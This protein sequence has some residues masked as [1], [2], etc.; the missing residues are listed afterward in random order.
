M[1]TRA[2]LD[3]P[4]PEP[5]PDPSTTLAVMV[6]HHTHWDREWWTT[7][8]DFAVRLAD[9]LDQ[10]LDILDAD[11]SFTT[12]VLDGQMV[13][14]EDYLELRP[15]QRARLVARIR[16]GRIHVGPW[17]V[18]A[19][20]LLPSG[21][22]AV[23]NLWLGRRVAREL[24]VPTMA[25]GYLP[26][27]FGHAAQLPQIL[28]GFGID[29]AVVW[30]GFGAPPPGQ[31]ADPNALDLAAP[32]ADG[33]PYYPRIFS[34]GRFPEEMQSEF[35]WE[36]PDGSRVLGIYLAHE[37]YVSHA[38][39][40]AL[41]DEAS[42]RG[43]VERERRTIDFLR[44]F[45][46]S[47]RVLHPY[48]GDH[49]PA[50]GRLPE[51]LRRLNAELEADGI[52]LTQ[53]SLVSYLDDARSDA[54]RIAITW[55]GEGRA[56]GR[57]AHLLPGVAS[58]RLYL[59]RL[60]R[61]AE[62]TLERHAEP[63]QALGWM[64]GD[65]YEGSALWAAWR[66]VVQNQPHDSIT[67]CSIDEV[68]RQNV[69]RYEEA[70]DLGRFLALRAGERLAAR[71]AIDD[72]SEG[73]RPFVVFN[74]LGFTRTD[75]A[76]TLVDPT[77]EVRPGAWR[78][79]ND[80]GAEVPF[81]A[82]QVTERRT[83]LPS[84]SWT[85]VAFVADAVPS[86]GY[87]RYHL[88]PREGAAARPWALDHTVL[89]IVARDKGAARTSGLA[90]GPGR[91]EN[92]ELRVLVSDRD[93]S[94][95]V[96]DV[97]SGEVYAGLN[98]L[99][100][101]GD[102]GD[103]YNHSWPIGDVRLSTRDVRPRLTWIETGPARATL[104]VSWALPVPESLSEDR[105]SRS[106]AWTRLE[107]HSDVTLHA[108]VPRVDIRTHGTNTARD[109]RLRALFPL[110]RAVELSKAESAFCVVGRPVAVDEVERGS[111]EPAVPEF[112]QQTFASVDAGGRGLT[113]ANRGLSEASVA[114]DGSGT[115][116]LTLIRAVGYLS[117]GDLLSRIEG[118]GPVMPTPEA[119]MEGPFEAEYSI[120][121]HAGSWSA[122][123]AHR[124]A[125][126]FNARLLSIDLPGSRPATDPW[127]RRPTGVAAD[128]P[129]RASFLEVEG[130][131]EISA[132]KR[133]EDRD[134]L[135]VRLLNESADPRPARIRPIRRGAVARRLN[136]A[137]E[138][139]ERLDIGADG[140]ISIEL[141]A[142]ELATIGI[143]LGP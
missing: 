12:F 6:Y 95:T 96:T 55:R 35:W 64:L 33:L 17:Y 69:A 13:M 121:P 124:E 106:S 48:G 86:L 72:L 97:R 88:V 18:L 5:P 76:R 41:E 11:P 129:G 4:T 94:L 142:W 87:R 79:V 136:L 28:R 81:Q 90:I 104:R 131:V 59:K 103:E 49:L 122:A 37:Y 139:A 14:L 140:W 135:V 30:R 39:D 70:I 2:T 100:D 125:H 46:S 56:F 137:E 111:A 116:A 26:D 108:G 83:A 128:L 71:V 34:R 123:G 65:P 24:G 40:G 20:T 63:L 62:I 80:R 54:G 133:A 73:A 23:R 115:V 132:M 92:D 61:E 9:L 43:W 101:G 51:L 10:L 60:N 126:A 77:L 118:A 53:D 52:R 119:Q 143:E 141:G 66:L 84:R 99:E 138:P 105:R 42:W 130:D 8:R 58:T 7:R 68:H 32:P 91:L 93:G 19:D 134:E 74:P 57:K 25:V 47:E 110:G 3:Q 113:I 21:E 89:G 107:V 31:G 22:S 85:E 109:H 120:I 117:R 112:P 1:T 16:E 38:P 127:R 67:G 15:E 114:D 50:D 78:L 29:G 98:V 75:A 45:A 27:Q 82:R 102:A 44:A 36:A